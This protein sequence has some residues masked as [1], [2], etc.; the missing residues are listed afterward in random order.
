M[1][2]LNEERRFRVQRG[3][4]PD[5]IGTPTNYK[6]DEFN[7]IPFFGNNPEGD[8]PHTYSGMFSFASSKTGQTQI[9]VR[10]RRHNGILEITVS[11][12]DRVAEYFGVAAHRFAEAIFEDASVP[13]KGAKVEEKET[14][15][16]QLKRELIGAQERIREMKKK[17]DN[18]KEML[19]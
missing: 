13:A 16:E 18:L 1:A 4:L 17:Q 8:R 19:K 3:L 14:E 11:G 15:I 6:A 12:D 9:D 10:G 7:W 2:D 5:E